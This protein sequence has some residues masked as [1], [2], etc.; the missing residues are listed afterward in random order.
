VLVACKD[1]W[2]SVRLRVYRHVHPVTQ[3]RE[4]QPNGNLQDNPRRYKGNFPNSLKYGYYG[5]SGRS[6]GKL[7]AWEDSSVECIANSI[8]TLYHR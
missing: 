4:S 5:G 6:C 7:G 8:Y 3:D 1:M 2:I